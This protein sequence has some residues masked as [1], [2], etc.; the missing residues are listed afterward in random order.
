MGHPAAEL[1]PRNMALPGPDRE[2]EPT[3]R[4]VK[5]HPDAT[6]AL[7]AASAAAAATTGGLVA[8]GVRG[9]VHAPTGPA[10]QQPRFRLVACGM[11]HTLAL[12]EGGAVFSWGSNDCGQLGLGKVW[13]FYV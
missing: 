6:A 10:A 1:G 8:R 5:M 12:T 4:R 11:Y 9:S 3:P 2:E 13:S 7:A